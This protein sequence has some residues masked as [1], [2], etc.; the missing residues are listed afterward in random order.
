M[1]CPN[2]SEEIN[3]IR[4]HGQLEGR[5]SFQFF[6][7]PKAERSE[8]LQGCPPSATGCPDARAVGQ[9]GAVSSG[10]CPEA[11]RF[12]ALAELWRSEAAEWLN[13]SM[14]EGSSVDRVRAGCYQAQLSQCA[15]EIEAILAENAGHCKGQRVL[16]GND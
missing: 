9:A 4:D 1:I 12:S 14:A 8:V 13:V 11:E 7:S 16:P 5:C 10:R 2:C 6:C 15:V 3:D